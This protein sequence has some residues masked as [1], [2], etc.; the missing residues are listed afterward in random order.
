MSNITIRSGSQKRQYAVIY[1]LICEG[2]VEGLVNGLSSI[3]LDNTPIA[4]ADV[5]AAFGPRRGTASGVSTTITF[6]TALL[7]GVSLANGQRYVQLFGAGAAPG[8]A[9]A[10]ENSSIVNTS[11]AFFTLDMAVPNLNSPARRNIRIEGAGPDGRDYEGVV[12][13]FINSTSA[14]VSPAIKT[15]VTGADIVID[16][17]GR[18]TNIASSTSCTVTPSIPR[19]V[20][21]APIQLLAAV[22]P[23]QSQDDYNFDN[24]IGDFVVGT[25]DQEPFN[26]IQGAPSA[27]FVHAQN[28]ELLWHS[29]F[30]GTAGSL[31]INPTAGTGLGLSSTQ[32]REIDKLKVSIECPGGLILR[33]EQGGRRVAVIELQMFLVY[34]RASGAA[35]ETVQVLG[36]PTSQIPSWA[37]SDRGV[38][39]R[40]PPSSP[41]IISNETESSFLEEFTIDLEQFQPLHEWRLEIK[42]C[43]PHDGVDYEPRTEHTAIVTAIVKT[44]EAQIVDRLNYP[45]SAIGMVSFSAE[46]FPSPPIRGYH[47]RGKKIKVPSNYIPA[48]EHGGLTGRYTRDVDSGVDTGDYQPWDGSFRGDMETFAIGHPNHDLVYSNNPA[49][50]F[51]DAITNPDYGLGEFVQER[52]VNKFALYQ[53]A[54]Y[55]D[56][57]VP[58]GKGG[59]EPRFA[60]NVY[61]QTREEAFKVL[62]DLASTFRGM[63]Y[64]MDGQMTAVQDRPSEPVYN[65][66][67]ANV[68]EGIFTYESVGE[69]ARYNQIKVTW[70]DPDQLYR[71][72][73][74]IVDDIDNII[75]TG[76]IVSKDVV[77]FGCTS[78]AQANR[79][80]RWHLLTSQLE[81]E[82]VKFQT[83]INAGFL[84][85]GEIINVQD[86][87]TDD[88]EFSGRLATGSTNTVLKLDRE[89]DLQ[90][91]QSYKVYVMFA[92]PAAYLQ[93]ASAVIGSVTYSRGDLI[94][95][96]DTKQQAINLVDDSGNS[97][98]V[99][100]SD[101][102]STE[103]REI[104]TAAGE[105]DEITV[106]EVF[107]E[108]PPAEAIWAISN[109]N[110]G[111]LD[112]PTKWRIIGIV[113]EPQEIYS[114]VAAKYSIEKYDEIEKGYLSTVDPYRP[115]STRDEIVPAVQDISIQLSST[116]GPDYESD[117][118]GLQALI[119]WK[120][121]VE[122][123]TDSNGNEVEKT[124]RFIDSYEVY[125]NLKNPNRGARFDKEILPSGK[126][127]LIVENVGQGNY[128]VRVRVRNTDGRYSRWVTYTQDTFGTQVPDIFLN[129]LTKMILGGTL[130]SPVSIA[131]PV[132]SITNSSYTFVSGI[133]RAFNVLSGSSAQLSLDFTGLANGDEAYWY[134][135][136]SSTPADPWLA[137]QIHTDG[138]VTNSAGSQ[139]DFAY[140]KTMN[141]ANN[142]LDL[143]SGTASI[144][145]GS[146]RLIG[147]GTSFLT[148]FAAGDLIKLSTEDD[149]TE[150]ATSAYYEV[151]KVIDDENI[152]TTV[153]AFKD[154]NSDY[155]YSQLLKPDFLQDTVIGKVRNSGGTFLLEMYAIT[156]GRQGEDGLAAWYVQLTN[157]AHVFPSDIS[158]NVASYTGFAS[159]ARVFFGATQY[160]YDDSGTPAPDTFSLNITDEDIDFAVSGSGLITVSNMTEDEAFLTV[161][162]IDNE[163]SEVIAIR[164]ISFAKAKSGAGVRGSGIFTFDVNDT[165]ELDATDAEDFAGTLTTTTAQ[166]AAEAVI[167][168][169]DDGFIRT[170]DRV[171]IADP[172]NEVAATRVYIGGSTPSPASVGT[173]DWSSIVVELFDG[174][175]VV[176][177]TLAADRIQADTTYA[178]SLKVTN[179]I[180]IGSPGVSNGVVR[181]INKGSYSDNSPGFWLGFDDDEPKVNI[182]GSA[183]YLRWTGTNLEV[184]GQIIVEAG[185]NVSPGADR[186]RDVMA[187]SSLINAGFE[188]GTLEGWRSTIGSGTTTVS[189][190]NPYSGNFHV[191]MEGGSGNTRIPNFYRMPVNAGDKVLA[192]AF[193]A[194]A[195]GSSGNVRVAIAWRDGAGVLT[196][197]RAFGNLVGGTSYAESRV[198]GVAP[199]NA[200]SADFEIER[201]TGTHDFIGDQATFIKLPLDADINALNTTNGPS[202]S[203]ATNN[204]TTINTSGNVA[205]NMTVISGGRIIVGNIDIQGNNQRILIS[206]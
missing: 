120:E 148:D 103:V 61:F 48:T 31:V 150:V 170:N 149:Y 68:L 206:D 158:G 73:V 171:T 57:L 85:P 137:A 25:R 4:N 126:N 153:A 152:I 194:R 98:F 34:R 99:S 169:S 11:A 130:N 51:Y 134:Y 111:R 82:V 167:E 24:A 168:A 52:D 9:T 203:G 58:D 16:Y 14:V 22:R 42:R 145:I 154:S 176:Q 183:Q 127:S 44:V 102:T 45:N 90:S 41:G 123:F 92:K 181:S 128:T 80:G 159:Q 91:G 135:R 38:T 185:S 157:E 109:V 129:R 151:A 166:N 84:R 12:V 86:K 172:L 142:G 1:D 186:T 3:Y 94:P 115:S 116:T 155:I 195:S 146:K 198:V 72:D 29:D 122:L 106:S 27:S 56:E 161:E 59:L 66:T 78:E 162:V 178:G 81:T 101:N 179:E 53:I 180:V 47:I 18:I 144:E 205:G 139:I 23:D 30:G 20:D 132:V 163:T 125:H 104:S 143:K 77:A 8:L 10:A 60:C 88:I 97:V 113:K 190:S 5:S 21:N 62:K 165:A 55:C 188:L 39:D 147:A 74:I 89:V 40:H 124:Y 95:N 6:D 93:Q 26:K 173:A 119:S 7:D 37:Q 87:H 138:V 174:S 96:V 76:K 65:F 19:T 49:W 193:V 17:V 46:D 75:E 54:R 79:V 117:S 175:V 114:I 33:R 184:K 112:A 71:Q 70:N 64:W 28:S 15:A 50:V 35:E 197:S 67:Q 160:T 43:T 13:Q 202:M 100:F 199:A 177:G 131:G 83:S 105:V 108:A 187:S 140:W 121:P 69:K 107:S 191:L 201:P 204:G 110:Y 136:Q 189:T 133:G 200:V 118:A 63:Q 156:A 2:E 182:G 32:A 192:S 164:L 141:A 36:R 196:G